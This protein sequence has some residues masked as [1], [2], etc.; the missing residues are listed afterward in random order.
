MELVRVDRA[1]AGKTSNFWFFVELIG[2][3][4]VIFCVGA[5]V[6]S[7]FWGIGYMLSGSIP[8][9]F[10][11]SRAWQDIIGA[12]L[13]AWAIFLFGGSVLDGW[14][15]LSGSDNFPVSVW[16]FVTEYWLI[17]LIGFLMLVDIVISAIWFSLIAG[18][19]VAAAIAVIA[20]YLWKLLCWIGRSLGNIVG[21]TFDDFLGEGPSEED[22]G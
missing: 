6:A 14:E 7:V 22:E 18:F 3:A 19:I 13:W 2:L 12:G 9:F 4:V 16:D 5:L 21:K 1:R 20:V 8:T 17:T 11:F 10:G 15:N